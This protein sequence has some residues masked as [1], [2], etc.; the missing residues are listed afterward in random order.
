MGSA[1]PGRRVAQGAIEQLPTSLPV[2]VPL[3]E[4]SALGRRGRVGH[5]GLQSADERRRELGRVG[6]ARDHQRG[7]CPIDRHRSRRLPFGLATVG[8]SIA[9]PRGP[10][11][12]MPHPDLRELGEDGRGCQVRSN[13]GDG[14]GDRHSRVPPSPDELV[15]RVS[16]DDRRTARG[17]LRAG[18][19]AGPSG[20]GTARRRCWGGVV[21]R[22]REHDLITAERTP[23]RS[24]P[25]DDID[26]IGQNGGPV[27]DS[28]G[29]PGRPGRGRWRTGHG[30]RGR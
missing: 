14:A 10:C 12:R 8:T 7:T 28:T 1:S 6:R 13:I 9:G 25:V 17:Y 18:L 2:E 27:G 4:R 24:P 26:A 11:S 21:H 20:R 23:I 15:D 22:P 5:G 30:R 29:R 3:D 16:A 19:S